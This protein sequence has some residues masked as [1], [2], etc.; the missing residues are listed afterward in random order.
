M[1]KC[2]LDLA[3]PLV[4]SL[5]PGLAT[6]L[7]GDRARSDPPAR[8]EALVKFDHLPRRAQYRAQAVYLAPSSQQGLFR[9][10][11]QFK[12]LQLEKLLSK[13]RRSN[14]ICVRRTLSDSFFILL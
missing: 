13:V 7:V 2:L 11:T 8:A 10:Q 14:V 1:L 4:K 3:R 5:H 9:C 6:V 12:Q